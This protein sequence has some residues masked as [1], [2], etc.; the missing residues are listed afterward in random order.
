MGRVRS[1]RATTGGPGGWAWL[2]KTTVVIWA[3]LGGG[4]AAGGSVR[5]TWPSGTEAEYSVVWG[6]VKPFWPRMFDA[7]VTLR[8]ATFGT[9]RSSGPLDTNSKI[10]EP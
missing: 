6:T 7:S 5:M 9:P 4:V 3:P 10:S 8:P 2:L 1:G